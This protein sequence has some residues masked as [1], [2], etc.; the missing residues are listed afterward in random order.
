MSV[1]LVEKSLPGIVTRDYPTV[2]GPRASEVYFRD[3]SI[4]ADALIGGEGAGLPLVEK[5]IDEATAPLCGGRR[6]HAQAARR[7]HRLR[8]P[9]QAVRPAHRQLPGA[10]APKGDMFINLEQ[11]C[12]R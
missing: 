7:R 4:P 6:L 12:M 5:V 10:A 11:S 3:V 9:A 8:P 2:D 1:F